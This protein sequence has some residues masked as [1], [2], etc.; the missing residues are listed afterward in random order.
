MDHLTFA[1]LLG[2]YGEFI[3]SIGVL[4]TLGYLAIQV[5]HARTDA[6]ASL[7]QHRSDAVRDLWLTLAKDEKLAVAYGEGIASIR[8]SKHP[9]HA[10]LEGIGMN[11]SDAVRMER[12]LAANFFHRQ[13]LFH[14][15]INNVEKK[16]LEQQLVQMY[17]DGLGS[18]WFDATFPQGG[19]HGFS[20]EFVQFVRTVRN[21][22]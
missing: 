19:G 12:F 4:A 9:A 6:R 5:R 13:T 17:K 3:A 11:F 2:N 16:E 20:D 7:Q 21:K 1:Q 10:V 14:S 22:Q 18:V 8:G 15:V